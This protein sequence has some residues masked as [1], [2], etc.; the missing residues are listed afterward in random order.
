MKFWIN[1]TPYTI[2]ISICIFGYIFSFTCGR[3]KDIEIL[4]KTVQNMTISE[5]LDWND[6]NQDE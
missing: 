2:S 4:G 6:N 5:V 3:K 1:K